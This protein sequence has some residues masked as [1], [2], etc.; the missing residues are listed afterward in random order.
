MSLP[1]YISQLAQKTDESGQ[2]LT[3]LWPEGCEANNEMRHPVGIKVG[4]VDVSDT[5]AELAILI[6]LSRSVWPNHARAYIGHVKG[7]LA[8]KLSMPCI[9]A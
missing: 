5:M 3:D 6:Q 2:F 9:A 1:P 7:N 8:Q 4:R